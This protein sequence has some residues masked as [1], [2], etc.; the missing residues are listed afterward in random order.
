MPLQDI[1]PLI[2]VLGLSPTG[3]YAIRELGRAGFPVLGVTDGLAC[4]ASSRFLSHP[5][6]FWLISEESELLHRLLALGRA[7]GV[8][9]VLLPTSDRYIEFVARHYEQ[10]IET[11]LLQ[12]SYQPD[13]VFNLLDKGRFYKLCAEHDLPAPGIWYPEGKSELVSLADE[14]PFPCILKPK[15]IHQAVGYLK[16]KKVLLAESRDAYLSLV[17]DIPETLDQW[18]IQEVIPGPESEILL[19]GGYFGGNSE[20]LETFTARKLRQYPPGFGSASLVQSETSREVHDLSV[21][22]LKAVGFQGVCG[23][24]FKR[25]ARDGKLKVIEINPRPTLWFQLSHASGKRIVETACLDLSGLP[26]KHT[27]SQRDGVLWRYALKDRY[28]QMFYRLKGRGF[29]FPPPDIPA[30]LGRNGRSWAVY[31]RDDPHPAW[32]EPKMYLKKLFSRL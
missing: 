29:V 14:L 8:P 11:F 18:V 5:D 12:K 20:P 21:R 31:D 23:T 25:D 19:F 27:E 9:P 17:A 13:Q 22:F 7:A 4:A 6:R 26:I 30:E 2:I 24:E 16:G 10:L 1:K 28:S 32:S 15:L 3:L